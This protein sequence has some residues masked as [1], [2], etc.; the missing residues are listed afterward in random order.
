MGNPGTDGSTEYGST[1]TYFWNGSNAAGS[2]ATGGATFGNI[3]T[4]WGGGFTSWEGFSY[5]NTKDISTP[6]YGNQYSSIT[7][8]G[9]FASDKYAVGYQPFSANWTITF[10]SSESFSGR[11]LY[12]TNTTY[13]YLSMRDGDSFGT[14]PFSLGGLDYLDLTITG[15]LGGST[16]SSVTFHLADFRSGPGYIVDAWTWV[17][18]TTL[19][20]I[21]ELRFA[22]SS[23]QGTIPTYFALDNLGAVPEPSSLLLTSLSIAFGAFIYARK[24]LHRC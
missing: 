1:G 16:T 10:G 14:T 6:G 4:D 18:L 9:A 13:A 17:D 21:D 2:F 7:G 19:G 15:Y 24:R 12:A 5:S 8:G 23:S 11:G 20:T 3:F 22:T